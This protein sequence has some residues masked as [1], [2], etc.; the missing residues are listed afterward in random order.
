MCYWSY[1]RN[2]INKWYFVTCTGTYSNIYYCSIYYYEADSYKIS[3]REKPAIVI[4]Y[5]KRKKSCICCWSLPSLTFFFPPIPSPPPP[6]FPQ[7]E[8]GHHQGIGNRKASCFLPFLCLFIFLLL[9]SFLAH[10]MVIF[11]LKAF[12]S[13]CWKFI[14]RAPL[15]SKNKLFCL[16][17][18]QL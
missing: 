2:F 13:Y 1:F 18:G 14:P 8:W 12:L 6:F 16:F 5:I 7:W 11:L 3:H 17:S 4:Q 10:Q 9:H 15:L